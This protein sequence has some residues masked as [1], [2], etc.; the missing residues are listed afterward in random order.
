MLQLNL[1]ICSVFVSIQLD[2]VLDDTHNN[3]DSDM[4][5]MHLLANILSLQVQTK[6]RVPQH[7]TLLFELRESSSLTQLFTS[8]ILEVCGVYK[9]THTYS[10]A[11]HDW[12]CDSRSLRFNSYTAAA[13]L[14]QYAVRI[15]WS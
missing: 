4:Y 3:T 15:S 10:N 2:A 9:L 8:G 5:V 6:A 7:G 1:C 13:V 12:P 14:G 11:V